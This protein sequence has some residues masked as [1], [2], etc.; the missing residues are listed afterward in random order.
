MRSTLYEEARL[1]DRFGC[2][3]EGGNFATGLLAHQNAMLAGGVFA[4]KL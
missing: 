2:R 4:L 3:L 1:L